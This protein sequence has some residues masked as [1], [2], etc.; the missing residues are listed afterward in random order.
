MKFIGY[1]ISS[2]ILFSSNSI[3]M[4]DNNIDIINWAA[5]TWRAVGEVPIYITAEDPLIIPIDFKMGPS[6]GELKDYKIEEKK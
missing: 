4:A 3:A 1:L 2:L 6:W 5:T